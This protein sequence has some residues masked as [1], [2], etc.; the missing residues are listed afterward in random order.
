MGRHSTARLLNVSRRAVPGQAR[1]AQAGLCRAGPARLARYDYQ[2]PDLLP[3][4]PSDCPCFEPGPSD[5]YLLVNLVFTLQLFFL[6]SDGWVRLTLVLARSAALV[7][8]R[9][10]PVSSA[11]AAPC[12]VSSR[13]GPQPHCTNPKS[14]SS[15]WL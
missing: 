2:S 4:W 1:L 10:S 11:R 3:S 15:R 7:C 8:K 6:P 12:L 9:D 13:G 14:I 5:L